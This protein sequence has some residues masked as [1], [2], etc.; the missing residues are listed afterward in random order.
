MKNHP[1]LFLLGSIATVFAIT[2]CSKSQSEDIKTDASNA[3]E[4]VKDAAGDAYDNAKDATSDAWDKVKSY[5]YDKK[6]DFDDEVESMS[7][8]MDAKI[9]KA[10]ADAQG[11]QASAARSA[12]WDE[13]KSDQATFHQKMQALGNASSATWN[14]AKA[15]VIAAWDK[16]QASYAKAKADM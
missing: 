8:Q 2:G 14:S 10:R 12:A 1:A 6:D 15:D 7:K 3:Y 13:V 11:A 16:L 5:T 9:S 4:N